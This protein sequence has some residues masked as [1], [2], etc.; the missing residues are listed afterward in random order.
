[1]SNGPYLCLPNI[2][3]IFQ[4]IKKLWNASKFGLEIRSGEITRKRT[5]QELSFLH[6]TLYQI[7]SN[8]LK[9]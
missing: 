3:K 7:L 4:T 1:M 8:Y 2:M 6:L 5:E 9:Q